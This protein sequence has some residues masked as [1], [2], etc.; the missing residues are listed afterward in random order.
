MLSSV[1]TVLL[2]EVDTTSDLGKRQDVGKRNS[3]Y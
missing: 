2:R 1:E 3:Y